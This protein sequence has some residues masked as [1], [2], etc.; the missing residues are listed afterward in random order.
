LAPDVTYVLDTQALR[1]LPGDLLRRAHDAGYDIAVSPYSLH[2]LLS[3]LGQVGKKG[4]PFDKRGQILKVKCCRILAEPHSAALA[5][6]DS[7]FDLHDEERRLLQS[8]LDLL[9]HSVQPDDQKELETAV[10]E[11]LLENS[12][13]IRELHFQLESDFRIIVQRVAARLEQ[14]L[15]LSGVEKIPDELIFAASRGP[16][17]RPDWATPGRDLHG[18]AVDRDAEGAHF[19]DFNWYSTSYILL[20]TREYILKK[21]SAAPPLPIDL[22]DM[23]DAA[24]CVHLILSQKTVLITADTGT[25]RVLTESQERLSRLTTLSEVTVWPG[26]RV[27]HTLKFADEI[28]RLASPNR[29]M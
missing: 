20:R 6:L 27:I 3:H 15:T 18:L 17:L 28:R 1:A 2:E 5:P 8:T 26:V 16:L 11:A 25:L 21:G 24:L 9:E 13:Q 12:E 14:A 23:E 7:S 19:F 22:H 10:Q 29:Q 4:I